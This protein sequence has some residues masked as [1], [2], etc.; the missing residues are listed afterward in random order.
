VVPEKKIFSMGVH[1]ISGH[2]KNPIKSLKIAAKNL[3]VI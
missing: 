1:Q 2:Q 3:N